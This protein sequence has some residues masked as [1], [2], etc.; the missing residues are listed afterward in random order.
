MKI[1]L[2]Q[3]KNPYLEKVGEFKQQPK[4]IDQP[5][6]KLNVITNQN[7]VINQNKVVVN[8]LTKGTILD[9]LI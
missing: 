3:V 9:V 7:K 2:I 6:T 5:N 1:N 8:N 4:M